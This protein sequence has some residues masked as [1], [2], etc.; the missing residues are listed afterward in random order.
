MSHRN[1]LE[2]LESRTHLAADLPGPPT[3]PGIHNVGRNIYVN[4]TVAADFV[5]VVRAPDTSDGAP[6][7]GEIQLTL[8]NAQPVFYPGDMKRFIIQGDAGNDTI[9]IDPGLP[10]SFRPRLI[11]IRGG[12][13][14]DT[15]TGSDRKDKI[16]GDG[17]DDLIIGFTGNDEL[18]GG[19]GNDRVDAGYGGD[20]VFGDEGNDVLIGGPG[21][22]KMFGGVGDDTFRNLESDAE[23]QFGATDILF[24]GGGNDSAD[25]APFD[26]YVLVPG[27]NPT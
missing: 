5:Q 6:R 7:P 9:R 18:H 25:T 17:G 2:P 10:G 27:R 24:G 1:P 19:A 11:V 22:D 14:N 3:L 23:R 13:G 15:I 16:F 8:N 4:G 20:R 26:R 21:N 12:D